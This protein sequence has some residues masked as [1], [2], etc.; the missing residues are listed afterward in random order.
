MEGPGY[1]VKRRPDLMGDI[2]KEFSLENT[3]LLRHSQCQ[4]HLPVFVDE[5][6]RHDHDSQDSCNQDQD[7]LDFIFR[8]KHRGAGCDSQKCPVIIAQRL[9]EKHPFL[10]IRSIGHQPGKL[11]LQPCGNLFGR[12]P[13]IEIVN[14]QILN[15]IM[16]L[17]IF[18]G[19]GAVPEMVPLM[20]DNSDKG[21]CIPIGCV[22]KHIGNGAE[23][24]ITVN[25]NCRRIALPIPQDTE[26]QLA[27]SVY[28]IF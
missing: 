10:P 19:V 23:R 17:F 28:G 18:Q 6:Y 2:R 4:L 11:Q 15:D 27:L 16:S 9:K 20:I 8:I 12:D 22:L 26:Q 3:F 5:P 14:L 1:A 21:S 24:Q 13:I 7:H 25:G